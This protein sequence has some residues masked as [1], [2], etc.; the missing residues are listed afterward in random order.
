M[1]QKFYLSTNV[2]KKVKIAEIICRYTQT[3]Q[4]SSCKIILKNHAQKVSRKVYFYAHQ[5]LAEKIHKN[6]YI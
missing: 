4:N 5:F 1:E 2:T 3:N 6:Y